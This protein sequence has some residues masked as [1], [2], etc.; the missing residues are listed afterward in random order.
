MRRTFLAL[1]IAGLLGGALFGLSGCYATHA[2]V[3]V[4]AS[5][6]PA[7]AYDGY[8][9]PY[10]RDGHVFVD[11]HWVWTAYGWQWRPGYWIAARPGFVYVQGYWDYWGGRWA[12]RPGVWARHRHGYVYLGGRWHRHRPG[13]RHFDHRRRTW[14]RHGGYRGHRYGPV[15]DHRTYR[16]RGHYR[17]RPSVRDH[18][19]GRVY[20]SEPSRRS[21]RR[22]R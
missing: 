16:S 5:S 4:E 12:Y 21:G 3:G 7:Y 10:Y 9:D 19:G 2:S 13:Y 1:M 18:R 8:Y 22:R 15:R 20:R 14:V 11:G 6:G 17:A